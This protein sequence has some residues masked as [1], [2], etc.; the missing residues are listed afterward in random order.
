MFIAKATKSEQVEIYVSN[1]LHGFL[2]F[3][4]TR[5]P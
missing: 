5:L 3:Q 2:N 1:V 4:K